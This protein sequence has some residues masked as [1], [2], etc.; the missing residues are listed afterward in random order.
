MTLRDPVFARLAELIAEER[1]PEFSANLRAE[2]L[3]RLRPRGLHPVWAILVGV[4][5]V[6][7]LGWA[8]HFVD[9]LY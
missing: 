6:S 3:R 1:P 2:A 7:Y 8:I 4:S 9:S 5:V